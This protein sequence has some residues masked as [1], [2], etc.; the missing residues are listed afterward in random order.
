VPGGCGA[1]WG[2]AL[3]ALGACAGRQARHQ[4]S[5]P[6][7]ALHRRR[8]WGAR[9]PGTHLDAGGAVW[10]EAGRKAVLCAPETAASR[11]ALQLHAALRPQLA[12]A[13]VVHPIGAAWLLRAAVR[14][15]HGAGGPQPTA[16][17]SQLLPS[18]ALRPRVWSPWLPK[19]GRKSLQ[20]TV[21]RG[22]YTGRKHTQSQ[23]TLQLFKK[24]KSKGVWGGG[25]NVSCSRK[26]R[27]VQACLIPGRS[28]SA[29]VRQAAAWGACHHGGRCLHAPRPERGARTRQDRH[30][31]VQPMCSGPVW[32]EAQLSAVGG[33]GL[34]GLSSGIR[35]RSGVTGHVQP[36]RRVPTRLG[37]LQGGS[38]RGLMMQAWARALTA[39][40]TQHAEPPADTPCHRH[41]ACAALVLVVVPPDVLGLLLKEL[42]GLA[43]PCEPR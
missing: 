35:R 37:S 19:A 18:S 3:R 6:P 30:T 9:T 4:P 17:K 43:L 20:R 36:G 10:V 1:P 13:L 29:N 25:V 26:V 12:A 11:W 14:G 24:D 21:A 23:T 42:Q 41:V 39:C 5:P 2:R 28:T 15:L 32:A 31:N 40:T 38:K 33:G 34:C 22:V 7:P 27:C 16:P 8:R